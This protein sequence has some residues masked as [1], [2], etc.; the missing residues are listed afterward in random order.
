MLDPSA[1]ERHLR[2]MI[3]EVLPWAT[4]RFQLSAR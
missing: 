1:A 4:R 2:F 3:R